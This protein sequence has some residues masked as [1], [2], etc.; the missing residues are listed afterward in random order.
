MNKEILTVVE[1]VS[2]EKGVEKEVILLGFS[3]GGSMTYRCGLSRPDLFEGAIILSSGFPEDATPYL[4]GDAKQTIFI[5]NG[6]QDNIER[7][8]NANAVLLQNG[9]NVRYEEYSIGHEI[10][11]DVINDV[12]DWIKSTL[13]A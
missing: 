8:R 13:A 4:S 12:V 9:Y 5:G 1:V 3:Q 6:L 11:Q 7:S 2:A 10:T